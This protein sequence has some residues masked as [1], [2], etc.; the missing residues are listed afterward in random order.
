[1]ALSM[2]IRPRKFRQRGG[3]SRQNNLQGGHGVKTTGPGGAVTCSQYA[4]SGVPPK[5]SHAAE[6]EAVGVRLVVG[7]EVVVVEHTDAEHGGVDACAEEEDG[8]EARHL[9]ENRGI[10]MKQ[11]DMI[12]ATDLNYHR[13]KS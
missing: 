11:L 3:V 12:L 13:H 5:H 10:W 9:V 4:D 7:G 2:W 8:E 6:L 1:M